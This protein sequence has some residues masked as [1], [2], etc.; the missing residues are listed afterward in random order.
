MMGDPGLSTECQEHETLTS[1]LWPLFYRRSSAEGTHV[2][3]GQ[4]PH[5]VLVSS[6]AGFQLH[7][8]SVFHILLQSGLHPILYLCSQ[9]LP[10]R[11]ETSLSPLSAIVP[12]FSRSFGGLSPRAGHMHAIPLLRST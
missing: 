6:Q 11:P 2:E 1:L 3:M 9:T 12:D 10:L 5:R 7:P 8:E 4:R